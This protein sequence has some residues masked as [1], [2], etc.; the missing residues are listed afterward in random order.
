MQNSKLSQKFLP[1]ITQNVNEIEK[2]FGEYLQH[3]EHENQEI[4]KDFA[5]L[6]KIFFGIFR[7][8]KKII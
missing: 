5:A 6:F 3:C 8:C 7:K 1:S 2:K 4:D